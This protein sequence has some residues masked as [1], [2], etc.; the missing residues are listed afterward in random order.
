LSSPPPPPSSSFLH[1]LRVTSPLVLESWKEK[2]V[3][4][5]EE[6]VGHSLMGVS[7]SSSSSGGD[8][9][10]SRSSK[11]GTGGGEGGGRRLSGS[12]DQSVLKIEEL[13]GHLLMGVSSSS[14][15]SS[16]GSSSGGGSSGGS[17]SKGG[18]RLSSR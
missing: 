18:S 12:R 10:S 2:I 17:S 4:K 16:S 5:T 3:L 11:K 9:S 7:C 13:V 8:G 1:F 15:S 14:G 6:L